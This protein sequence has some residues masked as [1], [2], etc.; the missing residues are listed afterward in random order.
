[1]ETDPSLLPSAVEEMLRYVTTFIAFF[2]TATKDTDYAGC[3]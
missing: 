1:M 3:P 2:R